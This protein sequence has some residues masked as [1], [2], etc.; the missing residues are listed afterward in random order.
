VSLVFVDGSGSRVHLVRDPRGGTTVTDLD[1]GEDLADALADG[2][3]HIDWLRLFGLGSAELLLLDPVHFERDTA[4][5]SDGPGHGGGGH[6]GG[7]HGGGG[8]GGGGHGGAAPGA[9]E[10]E[11][12]EARA[13]LAQVEEE[14]QQVMG[15]HHRV[16]ELRAGIGRLDEEIRQADERAARRRYDDAARTVARLEAEL[17][18]LRGAEPAERQV[19]EAAVAAVRLAAD[20]HAAVA[21]LDEARA[22]FGD[23]RRLDHRA[24]ERALG[25]PADAP[26][27]LD[28]LQAD[29]LA[30]SRRRA[31]L[32]ARLDAGAA[33]D[34]PAPSAPWVLT[35]ARQQHP[36]LW[37]RAERVT[38]ARTRAAEL[39]MGLGG[40]GQHGALVAEMEAAHQIV[41]EAE[42][43]VA[44]ARIKTLAVAAK[45]RLAK[46]EEEE[47]AVLHRAGF[48]SWLAFQM[49]RI[50][51][52]LEPDALEALR[53]AELEHQVASVAWAELAGDVE[54]DAALAARAEV[55]RY[56]TEMADAEHNVEATE[57]LHRELV[58]DAE[59]AF[60]AARAAL[61]EAC[62][63]FDVE[64][65]HAVSEV[66]AMV[67][68]ARHARLQQTV[69]DAETAHRRIEA[70]LEDHL[71]AAGRPG[72][73][74][75]A[76][77]LEAVAGLAAA[78]ALHLEATES[79]RSPEEVEAD[80]GRARAVLARLARPE[81]ENLPAPPA[82]PALSSAGPDRP[83]E[84]VP[85][86]GRNGADHPDG[87]PDPVEDETDRVARL[88]EER[89]RAVTEAG[90]A[91]RGL[92]DIDRLADRREALS[93][94]VAILE[95]SAGTGPLLVAAEEAEMVLLGR[96]A[97]TRRVGPEAE[98]VPVL[99]DDALTAFPRHEKWRL[100]DLLAR[101]G[102]ASQVVYLTDD[103]ET[104]EWARSRSV[105]G[106][107]ALLLDPDPVVSVA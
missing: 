34:L 86:D 32:V 76:A 66:A 71:A 52:L 50:D 102:E 81:W 3:G 83:A 64:P 49:R 43:D 22:A 55:E 40:A 95:T 105:N 36:E 12:A 89:A 60:A 100:L 13:V 74:H 42:R 101:L 85:S 16:E 8:H 93:R 30:A 25:L 69:E 107:V 103:E 44:S 15:R 106:G 28:R 96:F 18:I 35:L 38:A 17:G 24:L 84:G 67:S 57:L 26:D 14:Y 62:R 56:A 6:G 1:S 79:T 7:G 77:R 53:V 98:P 41:E 75:L 99:V 20:H 80:L 10:G 27:N 54:P 104:L 68:E 29:F 82:F 61:L 70:D 87:G 91:G 21:A 94:R 33:S 19:A 48:V 92:P 4:R 88:V 58:E 90:A 31:E 72:P 11:L 46:A 59:P 63:S 51:V 37:P 45:R 47:Q 97:Q 2:D 9:D 5:P 23:R 73:G 65:E 39:S 78:A